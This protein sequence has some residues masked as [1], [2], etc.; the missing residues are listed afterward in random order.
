MDIARFHNLLS[1]SYRESYSYLRRAVANAFGESLKKEASGFLAELL[2]EHIGNI[3]EKVHTS[4]IYKTEFK[5]FKHFPLEVGG[6]KVGLELAVAVDTRLMDRNAKAGYHPIKVEF[7]GR[8]YIKNLS[9]VITA[10]PW[11]KEILG[12]ILDIK[13]SEIKNIV[14]DFSLRIHEELTESFEEGREKAIVVQLFRVDVKFKENGQIADVRIDDIDSSYEENLWGVPEFGI[15][16]ID[17]LDVIKR[18]KNK[19]QHLERVSVSLGEEGKLEAVF[20][21]FLFLLGEFVELVA[22]KVIDILNG[23]GRIVL[24]SEEDWYE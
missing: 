22:I 3:Y 11:F 7:A 17:K 24:G 5:N 16:E 20:S 8:F 10:L 12:E 2:N 9:N 18:I 23:G 15:D 6:A 21:K 1:E 14:K 19:A 4:E 13:Y